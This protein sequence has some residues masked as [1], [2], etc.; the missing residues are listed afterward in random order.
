MEKKSKQSIKNK[1]YQELFKSFFY[2]YF[3][4]LFR[5]KKTLFIHDKQD[6]IVNKLSQ[7][8]P[9]SWI[10]LEDQEI[11]FLF[12]Q[13]LLQHGLKK[14]L[15]ESAKDSLK[16]IGFSPLTEKNTRFLHKQ[17]LKELVRTDYLVQKYSPQ[18]HFVVRHGFSEVQMVNPL[19]L[20]QL[21]TII[22]NK[23]VIVLSDKKEEILLKLKSLDDEVISK[24]ITKS[25][26]LNIPLMEDEQWFDKLDLL[27]VEVMK[28]DFDL[29]LLDIGLFNAHL[30][31]FVKSMSRQAIVLNILE[32]I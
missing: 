13:M 18:R 2:Q 15:S 9:Y 32:T 21:K 25:T 1:L 23:K 6:D 3:P 22:E 11:S 26:C 19:A 27:K 31:W 24:K 4:Y 10:Q 8:K 28:Q 12:D 29:I 20:S 14:K 17:Y 7:K 5:K 16:K 30:A